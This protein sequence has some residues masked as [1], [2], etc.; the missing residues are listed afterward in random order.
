MCVVIFKKR[1]EFIKLFAGELRLKRCSSRI[2]E[3]VIM[4]YSHG[5][6]VKLTE[7]MIKEIAG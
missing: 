2:R 6:G 5:L 1:I 7:S 3:K 4:D